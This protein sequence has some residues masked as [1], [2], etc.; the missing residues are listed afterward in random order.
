MKLNKYIDH[1][2]LKPE[3]TQEQVEKILA[4]AK[5]YDFASVCVNPTW[6]ALAAES[7]KDSDVKVCTVIGFPL[8]A[9]TPAVKTFETKD[10][11]SNGADEIDMVINIGA[12]KTGNYDLVLEDIKAVV[13]ASGDK[14]VKVIIEACLL[15]D[16]EKVKACQLSQEAGADYVK[17]STGFSTGGATVADVA[18]MRKT[19]GPD[20]G[21][22]A[23]GGARSYEDAIAFIEAGASRIGASSGVAIMNGAQ[24]D[25]DY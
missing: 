19:V 14:L 5:E 6:V 10:A 23:S 2:I 18:L 13:A 21:V 7:L 1:T 20:M 22:K 16:D 3:T 15:T 8:G 4:E 24:A 17:T 25:G 9:N 11:I 12:L